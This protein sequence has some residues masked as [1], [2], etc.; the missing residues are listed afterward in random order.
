MT[1]T[2]ETSIVKLVA[3]TSENQELKSKLAES[4]SQC[5]SLEQEL[6]FQTAKARELQDMLMLKSG[7]DKDDLMVMIMEHSLALAEKTLEID[8]LKMKLQKSEKERKMRDQERDAHSEM[9]AELNRFIREQQIEIQLLQDPE[10]LKPEDYEYDKVDSEFDKLCNIHDH[11]KDAKLAEPEPETDS[12][13][14]KE[15]DSTII[16]LQNDIKQMR[17]ERQQL[18]KK[19]EAQSA[20]ISILQ[21]R[22]KTREASNLAMVK[23][24]KESY[25][26]E[27]L[28]MQEELQ[29]LEAEIKELKTK[30]IEPPEPSES[31]RSVLLGELIDIGSFKQEPLLFLSDTKA[32]Y[33]V[34][35]DDSSEITASTVNL[36]DSDQSSPAA[37]PRHMYVSLD[38]YVNKPTTSGIFIQSIGFSTERCEI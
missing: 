6:R 25:Q 30:A 26:R 11:L 20:A 21:E 17:S 13:D 35:E 9:M 3:V 18:F 23:D 19:L 32:D 31:E 33:E 1:S 16:K 24:L 29:A 7:G 36:Y 8:H 4:R 2:S 22:S 28:E 37:S 27:K 12:S 38:A 34:F 5:E 15:R 14:L 10:S